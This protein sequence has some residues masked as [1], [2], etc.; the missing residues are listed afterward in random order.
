MKFG[1][2]KKSW[3]SL[4]VLFTLIFRFEKSFKHGDDAKFRGYVATN[5]E[6]LR[7]EVCNF[8]NYIIYC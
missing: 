1:T 6:P 7:E 8:E 4:Q 3:T 2:V 5:F